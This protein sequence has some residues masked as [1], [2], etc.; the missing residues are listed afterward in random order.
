MKVVR[1]FIGVDRL[2]V[3]HVANTWNSSEM[4]LPPCSREQRARCQSALPHE[5]RLSNGH[6]LRCRATLVTS[7]GQDA[8][9]HAGERISVCNVWRA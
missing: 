5:L 7:A 3:H 4:P 2:E 8:A 9:P 6:H 1:A